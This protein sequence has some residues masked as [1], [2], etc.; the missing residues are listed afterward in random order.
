MRM[1][2][3]FYFTILNMHLRCTCMTS[4]TIC[5]IYLLQ[6]CTLTEIEKII[7]HEVA[8]TKVEGDDTSKKNPKKATC[9]K[10]LVK[11][12]GLSYLHCSWYLLFFFPLFFNRIYL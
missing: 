9:K 4:P 2:P 6:V 5:N 3:T 7:D 12:K 11:W 10:Y 8:T 1:V